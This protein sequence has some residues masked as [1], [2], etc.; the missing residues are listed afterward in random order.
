MDEKFWLPTGADGA[1]PNVAL[2]ELSDE[3]RRKLLGDV[4]A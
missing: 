2:N 3:A 4:K 1:V